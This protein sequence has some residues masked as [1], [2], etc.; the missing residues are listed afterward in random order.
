M[1]STAYA[2]LGLIWKC[3]YILDRD[4]LQTIYFSFTCISQAVEYA[5]VILDHIPEYLSQK[6][7]N[8]QLEVARIVTGGN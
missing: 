7:E 4:N 3:K 6:I 2:K 8:I 5:D 1:I